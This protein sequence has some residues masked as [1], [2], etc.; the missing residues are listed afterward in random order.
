MVQA[1]ADVAKYGSVLG[2]RPIARCTLTLA[3]VDAMPGTARCQPLHDRELLER[4]F[5]AAAALSAMQP[6]VLRVHDQNHGARITL[7]MTKRVPLLACE[8]DPPLQGPPPSRV[9]ATLTVFDAS[10]CFASDVAGEAA[11]GG[12]LLVPPT[13]VF[14]R[15][16][17]VADRLSLTAPIQAEVFTPAGLEHVDVENLSEQG[18]LL[19]FRAGAAIAV[20]AKLP[21]TLWLPQGRVA[22]VA[23]VRWADASGDAHLCGVEFSAVQTDLRQRIGERRNAV[24]Q[25]V[26]QDAGC[27]IT[28]EAGATH[29]AEVLDLSETGLRVKLPT[30]CPLQSGQPVRIELALEGVPLKTAA[31]VRWVAAGKDVATAGLRFTTVLGQGRRQL[32]DFLLP[33]FQPGAGQVALADLDEAFQIYD[34]VNFCGTTGKGESAARTLDSGRE[35]WRK[36]LGGGRDLSAMVCVRES[37]RIVGVACM[38]RVYHST[39]LS[40]SMAAVRAEALLPAELLRVAHLQQMENEATSEFLLAFYLR[41]KDYSEPYYEQAMDAVPDPHL[42]FRMEVSVLD[43]DL[44]AGHL[45]RLAGL[46]TPDDRVGPATPKEE[47]QFLEGM[48]ARF[49]A[50][51]LQTV[52]LDKGVGLGMLTERHKALGLQRER[53]LLCQRR[54]GVPFAFALIELTSPGLTLNRATDGYWPFA[55]DPA[56]DAILETREVGPLV[57]A[58]CMTFA[59][60]RRSAVNGFFLRPPGQDLVVEGARVIPNLMVWC[61]HRDAGPDVRRFW[62]GVYGAY[63]LARLGLLGGRWPAHG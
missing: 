9:A 29:Q 51:Y 4:L 54:K 3:D 47:E 22:V 30:G 21:I 18:A 1:V 44:K 12:L 56:D 55:A 26:S 46:R 33:R 13:T 45:P 34:A 6:I 57:E 20:N 43:H 11:G 17:R 7:E 58:A 37:G 61:G 62:Q 52:D 36:L 15:R 28:D 23:A 39:W 59:G 25:D 10:Y 2:G 35:V 27:A 60:H 42:Q 41:S 50:L 8:L 16:R 24:R 40:H 38:S 53:V 63:K 14:L 5:G 31:E 32:L 49:P 19:R 48:R